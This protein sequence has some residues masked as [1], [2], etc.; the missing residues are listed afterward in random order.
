MGIELMEFIPVHT[1][2]KQVAIDGESA[3]QVTKKDKLMDFDEN[4]YAKAENTSFHNGVIEVK[5]LSRLLP[6]AP[7]F[8][9]RIH[10]DRLPYR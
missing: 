9:T 5:M 3:L 7:G 4:T 2:T 6:D 1:T 8:C 10:W